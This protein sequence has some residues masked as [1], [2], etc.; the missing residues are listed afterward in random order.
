MSESNYRPVSAPLDTQA[1]PPPKA[2]A[3]EY[4][5]DEPVYSKPEVEQIIAPYAARIAH[6]E[7]EMAEAKLQ[8]LADIGQDIERG[9]VQSIGED[10][11]FEGLAG[12]VYRAGSFNESI[13][14]PLNA[15]IAYIDGRPAGTAPAW[16]SVDDERKPEP[17]KPVLLFVRTLTRGEDDEGR[18]YET[19]GAQVEMGE[20]RKGESAEMSYFDCYASP[21]SDNDWITHWMPLPAAPCITDNSTDSVE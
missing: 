11:E 12:D 3:N 21:I 18:P 1:L 4:F 8:Q 16:I 2:P 15:L 9:P 10:A 5:S 19:E 7:R 6:L 17:K 14:K 20:Y 13:E